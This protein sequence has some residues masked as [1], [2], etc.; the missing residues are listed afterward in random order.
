[1]AKFTVYVL[2]L[3][4]GFFYVGRTTRGLAERLQEHYSGGASVWTDLHPPNNLIESF[5]TDDTTQEDATVKRFM[6]R[7]GID[8]VRGG[9][10][11]AERLFDYQ[12]RTLRAEINTM[13]GACFICSSPRHFASS[14]PN[15]KHCDRCG[16]SS[17]SIE[18]CYAVRHL[19]GTR[20]A[21]NMPETQL[22]VFSR[23]FPTSEFDGIEGVDFFCDD[24]DDE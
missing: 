20:L 19:N 18:T 9:S 12:M 16:R 21:V 3:A 24:D 1:M 4:G 22:P 5:E 23:F 11:S 13:T 8:M 17:H 6:A 15:K 10:Y 14:C 2:G 7:Y